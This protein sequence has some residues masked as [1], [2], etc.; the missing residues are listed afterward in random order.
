M[1]H[2]Q[3]ITSIWIIIRALRLTMSLS[4][5]LFLGNLSTFAQS[6]QSIEISPLV[7]G[8]NFTIAV[9][10]SPDVTEATATFSFRPGQPRAIEIP[11]T[12]QGQIW[13]GAGLV[14]SDLRLQLPGNAGAMAK[15]VLLSAGGK[16]EE[17]VI[18]LAVKV[19]SITAVFDGGVL[20]VT[21]DDQDNAITVGNDADGVLQVNG[22]LV[23]VTGGVP[24]ASNTSLIRIIGLRGDDILR[25]TD[26][27]GTMPRA[28]IAG[29]EGDD[30]LLGSIGDDDLEGGP[31]NDSISG[32]PNGH[33]RLLG[34]DGN[35]LLNG[36]R[37][38][39]DLFGGDGADVIDWLPGD[40]S[41]LVEGEDGQDTLLF[42]G[43]NGSEKVDISSNGQ[44]LRFFRDLGAI[45][46]DCDGIENVTFQALGGED[47]VNVGDL[48]GT[49][50]TN[51][52][53][54]LFATGNI[55]DEKADIVTVNGTAASDNIAITGSNGGA[56]VTGLTASVSVA[57]AKS[58]VD[59]LVVNSFA[60][61]DT[62]NASEVRSGAIDLTINGGIDNDTLTGGEGNDLF[63]GAQ[64]VDT[65]FGGAGD[66]ISLWNPG[67]GNDIIEGQA[68]EDT[69]LFNGANIGEKVVV[70]ANGSRLSF[71]RDIANIVMDCD[72][73]ETVVFTA[74][75]G[76]D[77]ITV[78][79]LS[80]TDVREVKIDLSAV[81]D[82]PGGDA[83][84]DS[85]IVKGTAGNDVITTAGS[86]G[87]VT[88]TGLSAAV[89]I[90]G[91]EA[92]NDTLIIEALDGDDVVQ[93]S[94]LEA[95]IIKLIE[96]GGNDDDNL[97]GSAGN[98]VLLG[99][100]GD[101]VL[102]GG[103]GLDVL[104]GGPG[105]NILIQD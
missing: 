69:L 96:D 66:D 52:S 71:T 79:D 56:S 4:S 92:A 41:D 53:V 65:E 3:Y 23:P 50:V 99:G 42:V 13:T 103:P 100:L 37:G 31:G 11:L 10:A 70:S 83:A 97:V 47:Q 33:D 12:Q 64:G 9:A 25:V 78:D 26:G 17:S 7:T 34:G 29:D 63:I 43:S 51:V 8:Q 1:K 18:Q 73:T 39:D 80:T 91:S 86:A 58:G 74:K 81:P 67:D 15:V 46:M 48:A 2:K 95:G 60:G 87:S 104:D 30:S 88:A 40:G 61:E 14:P 101:D 49:K 24:S 16:R 75:G 76:Q 93:A 45:T 38:N 85:V 84:A 55:D 35:D 90:L 5:V 36:N 54:D 62:V 68:D 28:S 102:V 59:R 98:D 94:G 22:G 57:G 72:D 77:L 19:E 21:G 105:G 32:G 27:N 44:R 89:T 6:A 20:T 82:V